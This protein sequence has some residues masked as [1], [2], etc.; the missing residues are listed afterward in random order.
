[1]T[2]GGPRPYRV[3]PPLPAQQIDWPAT[4]GTRFTL[5]VDVE[6]EFDWSAPPA[7]EHR[8]TTAMAAFPAA[9]RRFADRG[10]ALTC[11]VDHPIATDPRSVDI[12]TQILRDRRSTIGVQLHAWVTPPFDE[13]LTSVNSYAGNLP[14]A[15]EAAKIDA[16]T[17]AIQIAFGRTPLA[18]RA[19][20]YGIGPATLGLL[21]ARGY[22]IDSSVRARYDYA[23]DGGPDFGAIGTAAYRDGAMIELPLTTIFTGAARRGGAR[24]YRALGGIPHARGLFARAGLLSRIALTPE[25]M[26]IADALEAIEIA[27]G[28]GVRLLNLSFHSPSLVPGH[29]PYVRD[30]AALR[31]F[32]HWWDAVL[33]RL[34]RMG[35]ANASL[36][37]ILAAAG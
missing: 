4:F 36:A 23:A 13:S 35:V 3:P 19:G 12:L 30:A 32:H 2:R 28:E 24:L 31:R 16:M 9:H 6:E 34:D 5:F 14:P 29:T 10:V 1:M 21:A 7:R 15:M 17:H 22:R 33:D 26:P 25:D 27:V 11:M 18:Y 20:R 8:A 37:E